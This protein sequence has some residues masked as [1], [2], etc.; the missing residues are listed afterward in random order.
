MPKY[1]ILDLELA[2]GEDG[3]LEA[4][5]GGAASGDL[6]PFVDQLIRTLNGLKV[7]ARRRETNVY[8][9]Y[10][11]PQPSPAG[12]R[13]L[14]RKLK[15]LLFGH[16][17]PA[18]VNIAVTSACQCRCEHC[19]ADLF[20]RQGKLTRSDLDGEEIRRVVDEGID[21]GANLII[22]TG[23]EPLL[24]PD[25]VSLV[26]YVD[27]EKAVPMIFTN[28]YLLDGKRASALAGA[29]L[30]SVN[31]SVDDL[32]ASVH[33]GLRRLDG[34]HRGA[35]DALRASLDAGLLAG[36]STYATSENLAS[37]RLEALLEKAREEGANEVTIFDCIP[38]G[39]L[40]WRSDMMLS[41]EEKANVVELA[42][43]Y[44]ESEHPMGV[45][46]MSAVNSPHG[47]GCF[48][49]FS[50]VYVTCHGDVNPCDFN[51]VS[52]GSVRDLPLQAIWEKMVRHP[53][54][55]RRQM[56]CR[57]QSERYRTRYIDPIPRDLEFPIP[58]EA[59][60]GDGSFRREA[61]D[62]FMGRMKDCTGPGG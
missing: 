22:F 9:L 39:K 55:G 21:L 48:G 3:L 42:R 47:A 18:T 34:S 36:I 40:L 37:G 61:Y 30:Y 26:D 17:F 19:S 25:L 52:F 59:L 16:V 43:R 58:I 35:F 50:Q 29:G 46:A 14:T 7:I 33:D 31:I 2:L 62:L 57:M 54:F 45:I 20:Q 32:D 6:K 23:G 24:R 49:G 12:L 38:S 5:L 8:N 11:P 60:P 4:R 51:P 41:D 1:D 56:C 53:E 13:S 44:R 10:N 27:K 15:E 28:G